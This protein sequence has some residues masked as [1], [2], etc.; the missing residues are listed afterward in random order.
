MINIFSI[1]ALAA[2]ISA[3]R[4]KALALAGELPFAKDLSGHVL[5]TLPPYPRD[6]LLHINEVS[7]FEV[8][9]VDVETAESVY[10]TIFGTPMCFPL[11]I[12]LQSDTDDKWWLL[13][14]EPLISVGGGHQMTRRKVA[15]RKGRGTVKT[16][17]ALDD[18]SI[19]IEGL[20]TRVNEWS[21]PHEDFVKLRQMLESRQ[22]IEVRCQLFE[23]LS[24]G[25]IAVETWEFPFTKGEDNQAYQVKAWSDDEFSLLIKT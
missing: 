13:P 23:Y 21:Y 3:A 1:P 18:Y 17:W 24:I 5:P 11:S 15:K 20:L 7:G 22:P 25:R 12:K 6:T 4:S 16:I 19:T 9:T 8:D 14:T 10:Y 2:E